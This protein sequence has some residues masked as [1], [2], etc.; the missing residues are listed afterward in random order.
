M[1]WAGRVLGCFDE[2]INTVSRWDLKCGQSV[3]GWRIRA[4][5]LG[6][7]GLHRCRRSQLLVDVD[8]FGIEKIQKLL[9]L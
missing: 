1:K 6:E 4:V 8:N 7:G 2:C 3:G 9:T 5:P